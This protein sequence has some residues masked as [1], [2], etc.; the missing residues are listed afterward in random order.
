MF[1]PGVPWS[2]AIQAR[3]HH[4]TEKLGDDCKLWLDQPNGVWLWGLGSSGE[5]ARLF[6][7]NRSLAHSTRNHFPVAAHPEGV[8]SAPP[9]SSLAEGCLHR[10]ANNFPKLSPTLSSIRPR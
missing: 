9:F 8:A 7:F 4:N 3:G 2:F 6:S 10:Q 5:R 1:K